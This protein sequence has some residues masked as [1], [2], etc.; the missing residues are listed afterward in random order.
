VGTRIQ[1]LILIVGTGAFRG[2]EELKYVPTESKERKRKL[3]K[4][5]INSGTG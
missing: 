4:N 3:K 5:K 2:R 1:F